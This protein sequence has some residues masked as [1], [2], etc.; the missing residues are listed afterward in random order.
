[1]ALIFVL[2]FAGTDIPSC[3]NPTTPQSRLDVYF[4]DVG[5]GDAILVDYGAYEM[6][7]D[8][9][10]G[11]AGISRLIR[12][13]VDGDLDVVVA[14]H[15]HSD[16]IGGLPGVMAAFK[17]DSF[18]YNGEGSTTSIASILMS[19]AKNECAFM[20]VGRRDAQIHLGDVSLKVLN[21]TFRLSNN[22]N[23]NSLVLKLDYGRIAFLFEGDAEK[24]A[25]AS[26]I[27]SGTALKADILKVGHHGSSTSS[28]KSYLAKV[29]PSTAVYMAGAGNDYGHPHSETIASLREV[30]AAIYGTDVNGTVRIATDGNTYT[31][32]TSRNQAS[33]KA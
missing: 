16:H 12:Q 29:M 6:L 7:I 20:N 9:G 27:D 22:A 31:V 33:R 17:V 24:E 32:H 5:Q 14:T 11:D 23:N 21:P 10:E 15:P 8:G 26:I 18:W 19:S 30:G 2:A 4:F 28:S 1:L 25:E 3:P 13:Y